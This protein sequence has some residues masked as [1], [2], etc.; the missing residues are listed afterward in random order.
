MARLIYM[1]ESGVTGN[2]LL[3]KDQE[4]FS[5]AA[6]D[7]DECTAT[8][9]INSIRKVYSIK[10]KEL[11]FKLLNKRNNR[12]Q[13]ITDILHKINNNGAVVCFDKKYGLCAKFFEYIIEPCISNNNS[14]FY[15]SGFH[16]YITYELYK[17]LSINKNT[18]IINIIYD[19][20]NILKHA[21]KTY[22]AKIFLNKY[23]NV[24][25]KPKKYDFYNLICYWISNNK[26]CIYSELSDLSGDEDVDKYT[27][28]F[29][30]T[31]LFTLCAEMSSRHGEIEVVYDKSK[32]LDAHST[33]INSFVGKKLKFPSLNF[34][35]GKKNHIIN[36][37]KPFKSEDS[38]LSSSIQIA[39][40]I[41][42][43]TNTAFKEKDDVL[44]K[45]LI[46]Q[47]L[48][49]MLVAPKIHEQGIIQLYSKQYY[50]I[51]KQI[52]INNFNNKNPIRNNIYDKLYSLGLASNYLIKKYLT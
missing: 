37:A 47:G 2:D 24:V 34:L 5:F 50:N 15:Y 12:K 28:D 27:L 42:G 40:L 7:I 16:H 17:E 35:S 22:S 38:K 41:A 29:S 48:L 26:D 39:D 13:I 43:I 10:S 19:F 9:I 32:V 51:F 44:V 31:A 3:N 14:M 20:A 21:N 45:Q 18:D 36:I 23:G 8:R 6:T 30:Y 52:V 25:Q 11:K 49:S 4:F 33:I 46:K 1:D